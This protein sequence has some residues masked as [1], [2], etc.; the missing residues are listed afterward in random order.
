MKKIYTTLVIALLSINV[1]AQAPNWVWAKSAGGTS[2]NFYQNSVATDASGNVYATG[3]FSSATDVFG[4]TTLTNA[5]SEDMYLVKYD[6]SGTVIWAKS[7]GGTGDDAAFSVNTDV[8][9]NVYVT[10]HF[11]SPTI[12]FGTTTLTNAGGSNYDMFIVKYDTGGNVLWA[13]RAG[14]TGYDEGVSV[15]IDPTG[16]VY[17]TGNFDSFTMVAGSTTLTNTGSADMFL[18]KYDAAGAI[19]WAKSATGT[20]FDGGYSIAADAS[21]VY[22]TGTFSGL[23]FTIGT[24]TLTNADASGTNPDIFV[25]KYDVSGTVLWA[26]RGG[27]PDLD[28]GNSIAVD[29]SGNIY[30]TGQFRSTTASFNSLTL[31]NS[32]G[33][34]DIYVVKYDNNGNAIWARSAG[35]SGAA[36]YAESVVVSS[37]GV[38]IA[39]YFESSSITFGSTTLTNSGPS[40]IYI[41][42][43]D[44]AGTAVWAKSAGGSII[45]YGFSIALNATNDI[46]VTGYFR[47]STIVFGST[48][49]TNIG[50]STLDMYVAKLSSSSSVGINENQEIELNIYPNPFTSTTTISFSEEQKNTSL[51]ITD[52]LGNVVLQSIINNHQYTIDMSGYANGI[53]FVRI[54]DEKKNII[55]R[56]IIKQ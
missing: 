31:T 44:T 7:A 36:D 49:L 45:D 52:V 56:K 35:G 33:N 6:A 13:K 53:Y 41:V 15:T 29:A 40:D 42:K 25:A 20:G 26:K 21:G 3:N 4:T 22:I 46:Y 12:V 16:A 14:G 37:S 38:Y 1:F 51:K 11:K 55:N 43:Y 18:I 32:G 9:G 28:F 2:F 48:T 24:T 8:S 54:E 34:Y 50:T 47:S 19:L 17:V 30:L 23:H 27:G 39:G 10:G 5:G